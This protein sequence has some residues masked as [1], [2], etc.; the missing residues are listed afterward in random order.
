MCINRYNTYKHGI[1][2]KYY[3]YEYYINI[4]GIFGT[5]LTHGIFQEC[6]I[7]VN[8]GI[9]FSILPIIAIFQKITSLMAIS[10]FVSELSIQLS[11]NLNMQLSHC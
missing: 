6:K 5:V 7:H 10:V 8:Q 4:N 9:L 1:R 2:N 3:K 11:V